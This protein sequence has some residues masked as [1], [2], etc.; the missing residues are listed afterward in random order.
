MRAEGRLEEAEVSLIYIIQC[1]LQI[2]MGSF[3]VSTGERGAFFHIT[4]KGRGVERAGM[5]RGGTGGGGLVLLGFSFSFF[6]TKHIHLE[7]LPVLDSSPF[8]PS[9]PTL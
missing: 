5:G 7:M 1:C 9:C 2:R 3:N 8:P 4:L 6:L